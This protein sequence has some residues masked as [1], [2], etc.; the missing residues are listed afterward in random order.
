MGRHSAPG[1]DDVDVPSDAIGSTSL[2]L[3]PRTRGRHSSRDVDEPDEQRT[4]MIDVFSGELAL[5][6]PQ[7]TAVTS[8]PARL[9]DLDGPPDAGIVEASAAAE[10]TT[11]A[12]ERKAADKAAAEERKAADK[13]A[14]EERKAAT[15][16]AKAEKKSARGETNTQA[17]LRLLR[18]SSALRAQCIAA[19][20]AAFALYTLVMAIIGHLSDYAVFIFVPIVVSGVLLGVVLD[21]AHRRASRPPPPDETA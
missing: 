20:V 21:L 6:H 14:A 12:D 16:A 9:D 5:E 10:V 11:A 4:Q 19:V 18:T 1:A 13:A 15:R 3:S 7:D 8:A 2:D 17:D